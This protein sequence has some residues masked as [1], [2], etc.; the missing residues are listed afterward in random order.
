MTKNATFLSRRSFSA[1]VGAALLCPAIGRAD[2]VSTLSGVAFGTTWR[3]VASE[4][5]DLEAIGP[6][7]A[8]L[9]DDVDVA[10]SPWRSDSALSRFNR[11]DS[12]P[13]VVPGELAHVLQRALWLAEASDGCFDPTVGPL[14]ARWGFGPIAGS[15]RP[16][17]R[18][19]S[20]GA[21]SIA[22]ERADLTIDLCGIAKGRALDRAIMLL[23]SEGID[24]ALFELG[25]ELRA[26]GHHPSG[27]AWRVAVERP[28][29]DVDAA[30]VLRLP[31]SMAIATSGLQTQ[32]YAFAG[33]T[34]GHIINP[35]TRVPSETALRS[36]TVV[37]PDAMTADGWATALF[38]AGHV[39]GPALA[40]EHH[41]AAVFLIEEGPNW[42]QVATGQARELL[43]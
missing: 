23:T 39:L 38:A 33:H 18:A 41:L 21:G 29:V 30:A 36:V 24:N 12:G 42:R 5:A 7:I 14:V 43:L 20:V 28:S 11:G 8:D 35:H 22:K 25:G 1:L 27:R 34:Y 26:I 31:E 16:D 40:A 9:F 2:G 19:V 13:H 3:L 17:W 32:G 37:A 6:K 4:G 15:D 10:M